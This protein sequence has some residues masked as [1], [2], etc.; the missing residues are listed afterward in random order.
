[1]ISGNAVG[2]KEGAEV[3]EV[4]PG[5]VG[6][7]EGA[8]DVEPGVIIDGEQQDLFVGGRPPLVD[9]TVVLPEFADVGAAET[10]VG[11][12]LARAGGHQMSE[13]R[14]DIGFDVGAGALETA[15]PLHFIGHELIVGRVLQGQ[16]GFRGR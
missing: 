4:V 14:F 3:A 6:G 15:E 1:M 2:F 12:G 11:P 8:R 7:N 16:E 13:V 10:P 5:G 9:G